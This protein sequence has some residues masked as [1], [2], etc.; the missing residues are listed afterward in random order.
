MTLALFSPAFENGDAV[1]VK[2]TCEGENVSPPLKWRGAP[3][4]TKSFLLICD[5]P[6]A[7]QGTF[8]HWT[9]YNIP[10]EWRDLP[11]GLTPATPYVG[12]AQ[13]TNDFGRTGYGGP[14]PPKGDRSHRYRFRLA[15]LNSE[16]NVPDVWMGSAE[17][18]A[19][20]RPHIIE[21]AEVIGRFGR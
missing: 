21:T 19:L 13:A 17:I 18:E 2:Y 14:C 11:E 7:P 16:L 8:H 12:F 1:P 3:A 6:D 20:A 10:P 5:D 15:A 4:G 9:A